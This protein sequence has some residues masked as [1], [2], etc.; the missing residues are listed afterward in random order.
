MTP[1]ALTRAVTD[2][3]KNGIV[4]TAIRLPGEP[5][6]CATVF[7]R[8]PLRSLRKAELLHRARVAN[9]ELAEWY[10]TPVHP[11][12]PSELEAVHYR[13]GAC[14]EAE[15]RCG[16][17]VTLPTHPAVHRRDVRRAIEFLNARAAG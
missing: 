14:P 5:S 16:E 2:A 17:V 15:R 11:L 7:C 12:G 13:P 3:Y 9:V 1:S 4:S 6:N 8:Y 10:A